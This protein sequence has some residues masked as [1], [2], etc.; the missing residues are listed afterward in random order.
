MNVPSAANNATFGI[1]DDSDFIVGPVQRGDNVDLAL[2]RGF[3]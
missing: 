1:N 2:F 3:W